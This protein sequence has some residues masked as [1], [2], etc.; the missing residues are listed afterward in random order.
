MI[1]SQSEESTFPSSSCAHTNDN[2]EINAKC[3]HI[4]YYALII[5]YIFQD[6]REGKPCYIAK[7][8]IGKIVSN[9]ANF[10]V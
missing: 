2:V 1:A 3:I 7:T 5:C 8:K 6:I 10:T 9:M 4:L